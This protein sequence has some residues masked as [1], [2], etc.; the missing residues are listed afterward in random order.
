[1]V[2]VKSFASLDGNTLRDIYLDLVYYSTLYIGAVSI[3][4]TL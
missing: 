2:N 1:M 3:A 4:T